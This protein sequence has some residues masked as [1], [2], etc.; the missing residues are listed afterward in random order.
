MGQLHNV[1]P[2]HDRYLK[3]DSLQTGAFEKVYYRKIQ[4]GEI[5]RISL[6]DVCVYVC[7]TG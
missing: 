6:K 1:K 5:F 3:G 2:L 4:W 7:K